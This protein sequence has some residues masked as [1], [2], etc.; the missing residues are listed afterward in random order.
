[1]AIRRGDGERGLKETRKSRKY[2]KE[3]EDSLH[4]PPIVTS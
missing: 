2:K 1:M 3:D 4:P